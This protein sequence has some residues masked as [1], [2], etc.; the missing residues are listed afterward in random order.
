VLGLLIW[1]RPYER[2]S[3]NV[4]NIFIQ[5]VRALSVICILVF[6]EQLGIAQ[7]TQTI[8]GVILIAVQS[9]LT[10]LLA[11]LIAINA[12]ISCCR[13]NPHRRRRKEAGKK[14]PFAISTVKSID[15]GDAAK[16]G[17][18]IKTF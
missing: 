16:V 1:T 2:R 12:I 4:I 18:I 7:T 17:T 13:I 10:G 14:S 6:V 15:Q 8:T 3:G 5:V 9:A 11:L